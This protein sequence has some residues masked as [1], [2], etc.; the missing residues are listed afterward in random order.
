MSA[1]ESNPEIVGLH[2][3]PLEVETSWSDFLKSLAKRGL[4]VAK[5]VV[6]DAHQAIRP[7]LVL[8]FLTKAADRS[9]LRLSPQPSSRLAYSM[10]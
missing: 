4:K 2:T 9:R 5:L 1:T 3:G 6:S 8:T 7:S 10:G